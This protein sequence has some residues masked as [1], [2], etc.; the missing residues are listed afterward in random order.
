MPTPETPRLLV[1]CHDPVVSAGLSAVLREQCASGPLAAPGLFA[2]V[3]VADYEHGLALLQGQGPGPLPLHAAP[4]VLIVTRRDSEGDIRRA[5]ECGARGYLVLGCRLDEL[6]EAVG[7]VHR[8]LRYIGAAAAQRLAEGVGCTSL[9]CREAE[10]M[11][12]VVQGLG[13]KAIA[14]QLAIATGTVKSHLKAVFEKLD[15]KSRTEAAAI[16]GRRGLLA[17]SSRREGRREFPLRG[18]HNENTV[19]SGTR[20]AAVH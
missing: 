1:L 19:V 6:L 11:S 4:R 7:A 10:V 9:T 5:L 12:L 8:G 15:A 14:R 13:N 16:A 17:F 2:D 20:L 3:V 18:F